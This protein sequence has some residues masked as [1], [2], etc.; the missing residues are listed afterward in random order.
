LETANARLLICGNFETFTVGGKK[1][2][3]FTSLTISVTRLPIRR[4]DIPIL[5]R[6]AVAGK[7]VGWDVAN[8]IQ[9]NVV[10]DNLSELARYIAGLSMMADSRYEDAQV[11]FAPLLVEVKAKYSQRRVPVEIKRFV[12][13]VSE[14]YVISLVEGVRQRYLGELAKEKIF[15]LHAETIQKWEA[16]LREALRIKEHSPHALLLVAILRF[17]SG[18]IDGAVAAIRKGRASTPAEQQSP[19]DL[20]EAF[21]L[22]FTGR[23]RDAKKLYKKMVDSKY[24]PD[25]RLLWDVLQFLEQ[26][27][28][29]FPDKPQI[30]FLYALLNDEFGDRALG[31][32]EFEEFLTKVRDASDEHLKRWAREA[33]F[34]IARICQRS[35]PPE[36]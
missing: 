19:C 1:V 6:D 31:Q 26:A 14:V 4:E 10:A 3:G 25:P 17:L 16:S 23:L 7:Q 5:L 11:I 30:Q 32:K 13:T 24:V 28:S 15:Q 36:V 35:F 29:A 21:L 12:S 18:D 9:R 22:A 34:R 33:K 27:I 8:T 2:T 20:S